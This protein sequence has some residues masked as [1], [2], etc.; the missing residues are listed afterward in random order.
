MKKILFLILGIG[1]FF[2]S[3]LYSQEFTDQEINFDRAEVI[4][5]L[6]HEAEGKLSKEKL[7][8]YLQL[9]RKESVKIH[10]RR[11]SNL[12][13]NQ[14]RFI[15]ILNTG[16]SNMD[17]SNNTDDWT[18]HYSNNNY[19]V[20]PSQDPGSTA[21]YGNPGTTTIV[22]PSN[23]IRFD[24]VN[25]QN[26]DIPL[27][28]TINPN[29]NIGDNVLRLG[30]PDE[31][32]NG[33]NGGGDWAGW[34]QEEVSKSFTVTNQNSVLEYSYAIVFEN[35][36]HSNPNSFDVFIEVNGQ[37]LS[38][39]SVINYTFDQ[40]TNANGFI[41]SSAN[42]NDR[43][44]RWSTNRIDLLANPSINLGDVV[45]I[46][47]RVRD[48]NAGGHGSYAYVSARCLT[49]SD[50]IDVNSLSGNICVDEPITFTATA[51]I[52]T[53]STEFWSI[54]QGNTIIATYF[55][56]SIINHT[57]TQVGTYTVNYS[58]TP[59]NGC[60]FN[61][62]INVV[63]EE[64]VTCDDCETVGDSI[65]ASV[66]EYKDCDQF[67]LVIPEGA[68]DCYD[69]IF[70]S[71]EFGAQDVILNNTLMFNNTYIWDY[72]SNGFFTG[73]L[74]IIDQATGNQ[75][76][77]KRIP[78]QV[79]CCPDCRDV[80]ESIMQTTTDTS[81]CGEYQLEIP[82]GSLDCYKIVF[83]AG[84]VGSQDMAIDQNMLINDI[85]TW[86]YPDNGSYTA[87]ITIYTLPQGI[88]CFYDKVSIRVD[89]HTEPGCEWP[90]AIGSNN[91]NDPENNDSEYV[92]NTVEDSNGDIIA[93]GR[94][95]VGTNIEGT[96]IQNEGYMVKYDKDGCFLGLR[97]LPSIHYPWEVEIL[98]N[99]DM[100]VMSTELRPYFNTNKLYIDK[101]ASNGNNI[102]RAM[103]EV[104]LVDGNRNIRMTRNKTNGDIYVAIPR[105]SNS[106]GVATDTNGTTIEFEDTIILRFND[107]G[108]LTWSEEISTTSHFHPRT[109]AIDYDEQNQKLWVAF[110]AHENYEIDL[111]TTNVS[112]QLGQSQLPNS[113][114]LLSV[115]E[116]DVNAGNNVSFNSHFETDIQHDP[117]NTH[118]VSNGNYVYL[119]E[120]P[121]NVH[122]YTFNGNQVSTQTFQHRVIDFKHLDGTPEI[123]FQGARSAGSN[124][125]GFSKISN[126]STVWTK[127]YVTKFTWPFDMMIT[128]NEKIFV[129]GT[130]TNTET[131]FGT[132][133]GGIDGFISRFSE[134]NGTIDIDR[135]FVSNT[136]T[137]SDLEIK[138]F[139]N[140]T[141]TNTAINFEGIAPELVQSIEIHDIYGAL[142]Q[143]V[144]PDKASFNVQSLTP[145]LYFV[146]FHTPEGRIDKKLIIE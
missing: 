103:V 42:P 113:K 48:C 81:E 41:P 14:S 32:P 40:A 22:D 2:S 52:P 29:A 118:I 120:S 11:L 126:L 66:D 89:C 25:A 47:F 132:H 75:C 58:Y 91:P 24:V 100:I 112:I 133:I 80:G 136:S 9:I 20:R 140:P 12:Q 56:T 141:R 145:G 10:K 60:G 97:Q 69:I 50:S 124:G 16:C 142:K 54:L 38:G 45:T 72:Q 36:S 108:K 43:V 138:L 106:S 98:N 86:N 57:F 131:P 17:F 44:R 102:W 46:S 96:V 107:D 127:N 59:P 82:R 93:I 15:P 61:Y 49:N 27:G 85:F 5:E 116:Y 8:S 84:D 34:G 109:R 121:G 88:Q 18:Y 6:Q 115:I 78:L 130:F 87:A 55:G 71:G 35:P 53:G 63:V 114:F 68:F 51:Q 79:N 39:C 67:S 92:S 26:F 23:D 119:A 128:S 31:V 37:P 3:T 134:T 104:P 135:A 65:V 33:S 90:K 125:L 110:M 64:C 4:E 73:R 76:Y 111:E 144:R 137:G 21:Q 123:I 1:L 94:S 122:A 7:D 105:N 129:S 13:K 74:T 30:N 139:P 70:N 77:Y 101:I 62:S 95:R 143:R 28:Q 117:A 146:I 99:D 83:N 19:F